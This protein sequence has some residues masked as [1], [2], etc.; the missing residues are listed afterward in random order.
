MGPNQLPESAAVPA[1]SEESARAELFAK[2]EFRAPGWLVPLL[3]LLAIAGFGYFLFRVAAGGDPH[4][5]RVYLQD[6]MLFMGIAQGAV[7]YTVTMTISKSKWSR[8][9]RRLANSFVL[10]L[11]VA[12]LLSLP[13]Y[14][15]MDR[16]WPWVAHPLAEKAAYLNPTFFT[17][18]GLA[19]MAILFSVSLYF[20]YQ[21]VRLDAGLLRGRARGWRRDLYTR[22]SAGWRGD[23][24]EVAACDARRT[25][26]APILALVYVVT[27]SFVA[28]DYE[29]SLDPHWYSTLFGA[30]TFM[31]ALLSGI[32]A[33]GILVALLP[34][35]LGLE[36]Y[37]VPTH[38]HDQGKMTFALATFWMYL[39]WSQ[40]HVIWYGK[41]DEDWPY[42]LL[43]QNEYAPVVIGMVA[44]TW[45][46]PFIGLLGVAPKKNPA[47]LALFSAVV[48][49]G[50]WIQHWLVIVPSVA[51]AP[52]LPLGLDELLIT[53][54]FGG[55]F[56]L[57]TLAFLRAFPA[58]DTTVAHLVRPYRPV[59]PHP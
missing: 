7:I 14:F 36:R 51:S 19:A 6:L 12:F 37:L 8:P 13:L 54:G 57:T 59:Q 29:M 46:I 11:P 38:R 41:M 53:A 40:I 4:P 25:L 47:T 26:V 55:L 21:F 52:R 49:L 5:W 22:L 35:W 39:T 31:A 56:G 43:R 33:T 15:A 23:A 20:V 9:V 32:A 48:L 18:R 27:Y 45:F 1:L 17:I 50:Q 58:I 30:W 44:C 2:T 10:F 42:L 28:F 24:E 16:L 34:G 3:A